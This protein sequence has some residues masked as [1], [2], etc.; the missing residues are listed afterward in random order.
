MV[1]IEHVCLLDNRTVFSDFIYD[2]EPGYRQERIKV[3]GYR[4]DD[5]TGGLNI[6]GFV[7]D[8]V[9]ISEWDSW[10]DYAI[11]DTVKYKEFYYVAKQKI[12]GKE[13]FVDTDWQRLNGAP[14]SGLQANLDYKAKQFADFYDLD[15]D[16]FD[17]DQQRVAQHLIGYQKRK[18][19]EN[20]INDDVSQYKFYKGFIKVS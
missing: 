8:D 18:Y 4:T 5:W 20:I 6:P 12:P 19:L 2:L 11:G 13:V 7:Y 15:T 17:T 10:K 1:Q 14:Q 9:N 16:N 3:L